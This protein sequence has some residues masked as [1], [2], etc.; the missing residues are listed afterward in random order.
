[1]YNEELK[2]RFLEQYPLK[3]AETYKD[4]LMQIEESE[5][6][7]DR[8]VFNFT[9]EQ[10]DN[11]FKG[12]KAKTL[13][14]VRRI[15]SPILEYIRFANQEGFIK[16]KI[17]I[18][19]LFMGDK[20]NDYIWSHANRHSY[21]FREELYGLCEFL[22][23][24]VDK[25]IL[26]LAFEGID[27]REHFEMLNLKYTDVNFATGEIRVCNIEGEI[28]EIIIKDQRSLDILKESQLQD[29]Y[30]YGNG[31]PV[32]SKIKEAE[33]SDTPYVVRKIDKVNR[34]NSNSDVAGTGL[35][36]SKTTRFFKGKR[37]KN[38][39]EYINEP[40][41]SDSEFLNLNNIFKSGFFDYC[42][43]LEKERGELK[44]EDY[45]NACLRYGI[46]PKNLQSYKKQYLDWKTNI[47]D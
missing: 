19:N 7:Y 15:V 17:D 46:N 27:G 41:L 16:S 4:S 33:L 29:T 2:N 6:F 22:V 24:G 45:K 20:L 34:G 44:T 10:L 43:G 30:I 5:V 14:G 37:D 40:Y 11:A 8:D 26:V 42:M 23:N 36:L 32:Q 18:T 35:L 9:Y 13:S 3:T 47:L 25:A 12:M 38:T 28:R 1:M 21:I 39:G 31:E